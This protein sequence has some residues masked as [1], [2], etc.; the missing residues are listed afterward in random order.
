MVLRYQNQPFFYATDNGRFPWRD[1][2]FDVTWSEVNEAVLAV[3][4]GDG[5]VLIFDQSVPQVLCCLC[6]FSSIFFFNS[7]FLRVIHISQTLV[8]C[9]IQGPV[10]ILPGHTAEVKSMSMV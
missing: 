1:G 6:D 4:S 9:T 7:H 2:L 5:S 10:A 8:F 3:A